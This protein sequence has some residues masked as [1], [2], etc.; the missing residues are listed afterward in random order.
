MGTLP[1]QQAALQ[2]RR[3]IA[4][5]GWNAC[6]GNNNFNC[7][8]SR[9]GRSSQG[10]GWVDL[11]RSRTNACVSVTCEITCVNCTL[12]LTAARRCCATK[13]SYHITSRTTLQ[14]LHA[15][16][17]LCSAR[18]LRAVM[19]TCVILLMREYRVL[20]RIFG[21][22]HICNDVYTKYINKTKRIFLKM[23][24]HCLHSVFGLGNELHIEAPA[25]SGKMADRSH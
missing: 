19:Y 9:P 10:G 8:A 7:N 5:V 15:M 1:E 20:G 23:P 22:C 13:A 4:P 18:A 16:P 11:A 3:E 24:C 2:A 17:R 21:K 25:F 6:I 12:S 14:L